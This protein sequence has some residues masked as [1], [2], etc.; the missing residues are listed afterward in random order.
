MT[1]FTLGAIEVGRA[2][3]R[4]AGEVGQGSQRRGCCRRDDAPG[5]S[6][7]T[8]VGRT[9]LQVV[10]GVPIAWKRGKENELLGLEGTGQLVRFVWFADRTAGSNNS[11]LV[12]LLPGPIGRIGPEP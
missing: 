5:N 3:Q 11:I 7:G 1:G 10:V 9:T 2:F 4:T 12:R 8:I 6:G